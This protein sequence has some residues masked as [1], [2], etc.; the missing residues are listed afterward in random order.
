[1]K[2]WIYFPSRGDIKDHLEAQFICHDLDAEAHLLKSDQ[3]PSLLDEVRE[4]VRAVFYNH[5]FNSFTHFAICDKSRLKKPIF[6]L[7]VQLGLRVTPQGSPFL[8]LS[9]MDQDLADQII[10]EGKLDPELCNFDFH[11]IFTERVSKRVCTIY[12]GSTEEISLLRYVFRLNSTK[13]RRGVWQSKK[14]PRGDSSPSMATFLSPLYKEHTC[15]CPQIANCEGLLKTLGHLESKI[16]TSIC[17]ATCKVKKID[18]EFTSRCKKF[19]F[20][21]PFLP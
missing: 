9:V 7:R 13:I 14:L 16:P 21:F 8:L 10:N 6:Y 4:I 1:M 2:P 20:W 3:P 11:R 18:C 19:Y 5:H 15:R 12:A 17:C